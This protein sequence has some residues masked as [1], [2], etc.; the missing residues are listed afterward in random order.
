MKYIDLACR[1]S[2]SLTNDMRCGESDSQTLRIGCNWSVFLYFEIPSEAFFFH[3]KEARL[4]LFKLPVRCAQTPCIQQGT[5]YYACP[6]LEYF[7]IY[8]SR[9][10][11]PG[12]DDS[13]CLYYTDCADAAYTEIDVT[14]IARAW[15]KGEPENKG[16][17]LSGV[18][19]A[20]QLV[21]ASER[22]GVEGMRPFLRLSYEGVVQPLSTA[23]CTV[24]VN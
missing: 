11:P 21:Y 17:L 20:P 22:H 3:I 6:L 23:P 16:V 1:E 10:A 8:G 15:L 4:V 13:L 19:G 7:S 18:T 14:E 12:I 5:W 9:Y 24:K 2:V